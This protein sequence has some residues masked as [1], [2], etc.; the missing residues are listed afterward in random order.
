M[1][2]VSKIM[3]L[4]LLS[5]IFLLII[6]NAYAGKFDITT[7]YFSLSGKSSGKSSTVSGIGIYEAS[8]INTFKEKLEFFVGYS[9]ILVVERF[10]TILKMKE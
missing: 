6:S 7:G 4:K 2:K 1:L 10:L 8:Y 5:L 9:L 3:K